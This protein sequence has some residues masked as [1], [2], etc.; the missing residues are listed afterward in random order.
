[1]TGGSRYRTPGTRLWWSDVGEWIAAA[2]KI[3]RRRL[4]QQR[5]R[6]LQNHGGSMPRALIDLETDIDAIDDALDFLKYGPPGLARPQRGHR[7]KAAQTRIIMDL[8]NRRAA[9]VCQIDDMPEGDNWIAAR[10]SL[11]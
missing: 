4:S 3:D 8:M 6:A 11:G 5:Y 7:A 2:R 10:A 1:M 9:L